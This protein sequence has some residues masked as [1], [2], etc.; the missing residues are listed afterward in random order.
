[1]E[2]IDI[3]KMYVI[4]NSLYKREHVKKTVAGLAIEQIVKGCYRDSFWI[5]INIF[6]C[7]IEA[8]RKLNKSDFSK[9]DQI[10]KDSGCGW[11]YPK[12]N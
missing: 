12:N 1:M 2:N 6:R 5:T 9:L 4:A 7:K 3:E 11:Y 8:D 10:L